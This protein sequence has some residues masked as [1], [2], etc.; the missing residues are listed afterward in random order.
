M[1]TNTREFYNKKIKSQKS[2]EFLINIDAY[3]PYFIK[4][5][6]ICRI[7]KH[8]LNNPNQCSGCEENFCQDCLSEF[9]KSNKYCINSCSLSNPMKTHPAIINFMEKLKFRCIFNNN[10]IINYNDID[11]HLISECKFRQFL[12]KF[13]EC[14]YYGSKDEVTKHIETC[15]FQIVFCPI[16]K[17]TYKTKDKHDCAEYFIFKY[18]KTKEMYKEMIKNYEVEFKKLNELVDLINVK[19]TEK[20]IF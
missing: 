4:T 8:L 19:I 10:E 16:C 7:C 6:F 3:D 15:E 9:S 17:L 12:C 5:H 14:D 18:N 13:K 11:R 1:E 20:K 2:L